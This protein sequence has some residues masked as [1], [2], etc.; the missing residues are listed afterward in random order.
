MD[1]KPA[2]VGDRVGIP[3]QQV[4]ANFSALLEKLGCR[5][6]IVQIHQ[7]EAGPVERHRQAASVAVGRFQ[8]HHAPIGFD[9]FL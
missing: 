6:G 2:P 4:L 9:R 7:R 3:R 1:G 8:F 5:G